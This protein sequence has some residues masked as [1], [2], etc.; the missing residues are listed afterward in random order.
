MADEDPERFPRGPTMT[1]RQ[2]R[3]SKEEFARRGTEL[4]EQKIRPLVESGHR[5]RV[6]AIDIETGDYEL[7][8]DTLEA[9][10]QLIARRP[11]A[12]PWCVRIGHRA[13]EHFGFHSTVE[14]P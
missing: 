4:Y 6:V 8:D 12:Q 9:C 11:E 13:V 14:K 2:P 3:Y 7:A 10:Q 1:A 5:G